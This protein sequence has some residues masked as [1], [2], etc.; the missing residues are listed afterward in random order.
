MEKMYERREDGGKERK[1]EGEGADTRIYSGLTGLT[2]V[3]IL[4]YDLQDS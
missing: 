1:E 4:T 3:K 2:R